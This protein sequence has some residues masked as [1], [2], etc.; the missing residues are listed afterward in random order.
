MIIYFIVLLLVMILLTMDQRLKVAQNKTSIYQVIAGVVLVLFEG[1][2]SNFVGTD[3]NNYV[4]IFNGLQYGT[5]EF[6]DKNSTIEFGYM[7]LQKVAYIISPHYWSLLTMIAFVGVFISFKSFNLLSLNFKL[8]VFLFITLASYLFL[9]NG[10]RQGLAACVYGIAFFYLVSKKLWYYMLWVF[11]ATLFHKTAV[12]MVPFFY[13]LHWKLSVKKMLLFVLLSV[14]S[15]LYL[16]T[17]LSFFEDSVQ[18][19]YAVYENRGAQGG[20]LLGLFF[21]LLSFYLVYLRKKIAAIN[22]ERYN[23]YLNTCVFSSLIY[24][25]VIATGRDVNFIRLSLYFMIGYFLIWPIIFK[26]VKF[27]KSS[28]GKLIFYTVHLVFFAVYL[29]KMSSLTPYQFNLNLLN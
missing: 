18:D 25:V 10:A 8:S 12:I 21:I 23:I 22:Q 9:F 11:I 20:L 26:D 14:I 7:M 5:Y 4:G 1:F 28:F 2:R 27:F 13:I 24:F 29:S 15:L 16:S 17:F 19:R 6:I 3:T